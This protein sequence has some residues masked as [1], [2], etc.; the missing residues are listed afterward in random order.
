MFG[1]ALIDRSDCFLGEPQWQAAFCRFIRTEKS[2]H[3]RLELK[4]WSLEVLVPGFMREADEIIYGHREGSTNDLFMRMRRH[5]L[6]S[7]RLEE[8]ASCETDNSEKVCYRMLENLALAYG[9]DI[10][11]NRTMIS[12]EPLSPG[13]GIL[14]DETMDLAN[15]IFATG[16]HLQLHAPRADLLIARA[17]QVA[18]MAESTH[19]LVQ[20]ATEGRLDVLRNGRITPEIWETQSRGVGRKELVGGFSSLYDTTS[21]PL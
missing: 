8:E 19:T 2:L 17:T 12:L 9:A 7:L 15:K 1:E 14:E 6:E 5:K 20:A 3:K 18:R 21:T 10:L 13:S 4:L 16:S 11:V